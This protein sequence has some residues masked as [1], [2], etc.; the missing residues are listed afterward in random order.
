MRAFFCLTLLLFFYSAQSQPKTDTFLQKILSAN[1]DS[2]FQKVLSHPEYYRLQI[3][4]TQ[5]NRDKNNQPFFKNYYFNVDSLFYF[6]PASTVKLPLAALS[7]EK[8]NAR[9]IAGV[10]KY[11]SMQF[12]SAY[13]HQVKELYD[14]T[15]ET[16]FPSIAHFIKKAFLISDNDAYNRMYQF[17][18]QQT[19]NRKL[20][21]KAYKSIRITREF[22]GFTEDENRHTNPINFI[23][24]DGKVIYT[25]PARY[26]T[27]SFDFSHTVKIGKAHYDN[28]DSL[29]NEPIDFTKVNNL[30][31]EDLRQIL[32]T[33]LF[34]TSVPQKQRFDLTKDDYGFLKQFLSQY[35]SE[36]NYPKY[37]TSQYYD[38]YV[39]FYFQDI[40]HK[41]PSYIRVFNKVGWAYGFLID[42]SYVVDFKNNVEFMLASTVYVNSDEILN[43]DKYDYETIGH[44]FMYQLGQTIY[45]YELNRKR[46]YS[47]DLSD[48]RINYEHRNANDNRPSIKDA[49]N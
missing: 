15:S 31:L 49:D 28:K 41:M 20:R 42:A 32:Q 48:F 3:I 13:T 4:Y 35:P 47:P 36:T 30:P 24:K 5:I 25:Q 2:I 27:D 6:N 8:L 19:I 38:S 23:D 1:K 34:P 22:M 39:K 37:D 12:D 45:N 33:I 46:K 10:D 7:L 18:G 17:V 44:P 26:N 43:D 14:S 11:T 9:K 21:E 40:T 16:N 29:I